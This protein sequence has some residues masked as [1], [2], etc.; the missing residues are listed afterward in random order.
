MRI[1]LT[2]KGDKNKAR[3]DA[4]RRKTA[5][6]LMKAEDLYNRHL[7]NDTVDDKRW[8]VSVKLEILWLILAAPN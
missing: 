5:Q 2:S 4:V 3:R 8:S 6:Y 1:I 7:A